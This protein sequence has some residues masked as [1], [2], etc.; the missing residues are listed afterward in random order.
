MARAL[1]IF[2]EVPEVTYDADLSG[3]AVR[4]T[5]R[6]LE[7]TAGWYFNIAE[8][9]GTVIVQGRRVGD[10]RT[11][12]EGLRILHR[13]GDAEILIPIGGDD[14]RLDPPVAILMPRPERSTEDLGLTVEAGE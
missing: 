2:P 11:P 6:W 3:V 4:V 12:L 1:P 9:D 13:I 5:V 8:P 14:S 10:K 7:R